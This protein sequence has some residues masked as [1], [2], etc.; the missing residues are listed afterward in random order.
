M[1]IYSKLALAALTALL[2]LSIGAGTAFASRGIELSPKGANSAAGTLTFSSPEAE[3]IRIRCRVTLTLANV[4]ENG[5]AKSTATLVANIT[6][7]RVENCEGGTVRVLSPE[8]GRPWRATYVSFAGTL[9]SITSV[10][11]ELRGVAFLISSFVSCLY[12][13]NAQGTTVGSPV[14]ELRAD[15]SI[16]IPLVRA[17]TIGCPA[18]GNFSGSMRLERAITLRLV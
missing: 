11:L 7:V 16:T 4:G 10:R 1:R 15:E 5:T 13:G 12:G 18:E 2:V 3:G 14:S 9:P 8:V 6:A 17:L